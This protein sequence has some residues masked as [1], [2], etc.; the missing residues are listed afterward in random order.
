[1]SN[2]YKTSG[3][4]NTDSKSYDVGLRSYMQRV[5]SLMALALFVTAAVSFFS[6]QSDS[7]MRAI[8]FSPLRWVV[9][10]APLIF[11]FVFYSK[12]NNISA[13]SAKNYLWIF[14]SLMGLSLSYIFLA[15]TGVSIVRTFLITSSMFG[16]MSFY[17]Y[18]TKK[19]LSSWGSFL[20]MGLIGLIIASIVNIF[21]QSSAMD[22]AI[23]FIGVIVFTGLTAYDTQKIKNIY[24]N[25]ANN[26]D[27]ATI[28]KF[29]IMGAL[30]LYIDFINLFLMLLRFFGERR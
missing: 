14:S 28:Q 29:A 9:M 23:S 5:Y 11:V 26:S 30:N 10:F 19:D 22:F 3:F 2:I 13:N 6:A 25:I 15:Y 24:Y 17:G 7:L 12:I 27:A 20:L 16:A 8:H 4:A 21:L 1:M 18:V